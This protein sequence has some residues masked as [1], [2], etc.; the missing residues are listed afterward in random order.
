MGSFTRSTRQVIH[1]VRP[2]KRRKSERKSKVEIQPSRS[3]VSCWPYP[4]FTSQGKLCRTCRCRCPCV[5]GCCNGIPSRSHHCP[6]W[7]SSQHPGCTSA[8]EVREGCQ[9]LITT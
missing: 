1:H 7:S 8:K 9:G 3:S 6:G 5:H 2:W 4:S